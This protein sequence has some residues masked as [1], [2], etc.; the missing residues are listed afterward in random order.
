[1]QVEVKKA[2]PRDVK[3]AADCSQ[4]DPTS[5]LLITQSNES[6]LTPAAAPGAAA[7]AAANARDDDDAVLV[8]THFTGSLLMSQAAHTCLIE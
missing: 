4:L 8:S 5:S 7:A 6:R 3:L 2:E 1:M